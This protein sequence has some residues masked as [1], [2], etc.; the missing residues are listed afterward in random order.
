MFFFLVFL[1][2]LFRFCLSMPCSIVANFETHNLSGTFVSLLAEL[3][4]KSSVTTV[5]VALSKQ[6]MH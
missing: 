5:H 3:W 1:K 2:I 6:P 4:Q